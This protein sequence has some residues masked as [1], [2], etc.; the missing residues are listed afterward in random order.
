[1][2]NSVKDFDLAMAGQDIDLQETGRGGRGGGCVG[3]VREEEGGLCVQTVDLQC[4]CV[5]QSQ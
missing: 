5:H 2:T 3:E 1:V 4:C